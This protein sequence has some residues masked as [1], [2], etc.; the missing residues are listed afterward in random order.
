MLIFMDYIIIPIF[1]DSGG[2]RLT[3]VS[4]VSEPSTVFPV[5]RLLIK[6]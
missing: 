6:N 2:C 3:V 5:A 1:R 4:L